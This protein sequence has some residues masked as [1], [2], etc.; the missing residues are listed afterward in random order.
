MMQRGCSWLEIDLLPPQ[1][2]QVCIFVP[3]FSFILSFAFLMPSLSLGTKGIKFP[4]AMF[5]HGLFYQWELGGNQDWA[6]I[7]SISVGIR[8][9]LYPEPSF[10]NFQDG[11]N[12]A[13]LL[14][15]VTKFQWESLPTK[16]GN[17]L[18]RQQKS[19]SE[20]IKSLRGYHTCPDR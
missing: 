20:T 5:L 4:R 19:K 3:S 6:R 11:D 17:D 7:S 12:G 15:I 8:K 13:N 18:Q 14:G 2:N 9:F 1:D 10:T 16:Q